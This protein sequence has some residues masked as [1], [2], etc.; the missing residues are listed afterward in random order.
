MTGN[1]AMFLF[2]AVPKEVDC[3][4]PLLSVCSGAFMT[5]GVLDGMSKS[6]TTLLE[7]N[8]SRFGAAWS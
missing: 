1:E 4:V 2:L 7:F 3:E 8:T 5:P 6:C